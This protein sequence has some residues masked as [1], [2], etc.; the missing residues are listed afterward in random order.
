M[1]RSHLASALPIVIAISPYY[2]ESKQNFPLSFTKN[3]LK[4]L[5]VGSSSI[6]MLNCSDRDCKGGS[7]EAVK[8]FRSGDFGDAGESPL[9]FVFAEANPP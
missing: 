7:N 6:M 5:R 1:P 2:K 4:R 3:R 9:E 8:L